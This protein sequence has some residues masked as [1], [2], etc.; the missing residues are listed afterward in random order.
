MKKSNLSKAEQHRQAEE[1]LSK[2]AVTTRRLTKADTLSIVREL[3]INQ[4]KLEIQ[5][6]E[7]AQ[8]RAEAEAAYRQYTDLY[9]FAPV[10]YFTLAYDGA[11]IEVNLA[12]AELL[13]V[14]HVK[15]LNQRLGLF[16][17]E[18]SRPIF[19]DFLEKLLSCEGKETCEVAFQKNENGLVWVRIEATCFEG[20][21][22]CHAVVMD[23][24]ARKQISSL[25]RARVRISEFV[26]SHTL[27]ELLQKMLD[28]A[29]LLTDSQIGFAHFLEADQKTLELQTWST[30]TL[31]NMCT[32]AGKGS[33][34]PVDEAGVWAECVSTRAPAIHNDYAHLSHRKGLPP[35]HAP[36]L[37]EIIVPVL[38]N[39]LVVM[40]VGVGNKSTNYNDQDVSILSQLANAAWDIVQRKQAEDALRESE[41]RN[42]IVSELITDYIFIVDVDSGRNLKFRWASNNM[43]RLTGRTIQEAATSDDW[44]SIIHPGDLARFFDFIDKTLSTAESGEFECRTFNKDGGG[45]WV[46]VFVRPQADK[47]GKVTTIV[48]AVQDTT[49]RKQMEDALRENQELFSLFMHFS[50]I[51]A[52]I[53]ESTPTESRVIQASDNYQEMIGISGRDMAGKT[54][55]ELFPPEFAAKFTADDWAVVAGGEVLKLDEDMNGR[56]YTTIKFPIVL[57]D[58]TLLAGYTIDITKRVQAEKALR[59]SE[60][61]YRTVANFTYDWETWRGPD[62]AFLYVSP[63]CERITGHTVAEFLTDPDLILKITHPDDQP[64]IREHFEASLDRSKRKDLHLDFR[65]ITPEGKTRWLSHNCVAVYGEDGRWLG[66]RESTRD[67]TERKLAEMN[68]QY[69]KEGLEAANRELQSTLT[70]EQQLAR[71]DSLTGVFNRRH[72][73]E[74]ARHEI[75]VAERYQRP[76]SVIMF[77][78]DHFKK[79]N[80]IFGHTAGDHLLERVAQ[81]ACAELRSADVI[82]RYGG[83]EFIVLLPMTN[84]QQ[85]YPLAERIRADVAA[86]RVP[87]LKGDAFVT[88]SIGIVEMMRTTPT[89]SVEDVFRRVD[90]AMY[91]AKQAGR[92]RTEIGNP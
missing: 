65:I 41:W 14:E 77:D 40:I 4:I 53:K 13:G 90:E 26:E 45:R 83:E 64:H 55:D 23:I 78:I 57:R 10:G 70:R 7:L 74:I 61:K 81:V 20:G 39:D 9:D 87:T 56:N 35:G 31:K 38:H 1:K 43:F 79:V 68:L 6:E 5:N 21:Q 36:V 22:E 48:G 17:S 66:R 80:D 49:E 51:Y 75:E 69:M 85:A 63:S 73:Y 88:L 42:R 62:G 92:N 71:I 50:P 58:K 24:T 37:R 84:A 52:F 59:V 91:A 47:D 25:L 86:L 30:N 18:E 28:E 33:H 82:G 46:R 76:L 12:G 89:E 60:E 54:M 11:I 15:L 29:E 8:A 32:A 19:N 16:V 44:A 3:Q 67:I 27:D 2:Q 34:Y 72:L